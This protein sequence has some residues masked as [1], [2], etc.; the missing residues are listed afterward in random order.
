[1]YKQ[2][3]FWFPSSSRPV[4]ISTAT[5]LS[6]LRF[7]SSFSFFGLDLSFEE[8]NDANIPNALPRLEDCPSCSNQESTSTCQRASN[9]PFAISR[10]STQWATSSGPE[11]FNPR[12][13]QPT[14]SFF[15]ILRLALLLLLLLAML[16]LS[17]SK[18]SSRGGVVNRSSLYS[19][20]FSA[21]KI[22]VLLSNEASTESFE[23]HSLCD[24]GI[25][26]LPR[27]A[28][29]KGSREKSL[30]VTNILCSPVS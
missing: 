5:I 2:V 14:I 25:P 23:L 12:L 28:I 3:G 17:S 16:L 6:W 24:D 4:S 27:S 7:W 30:G 18:L 11:E 9:S 22:P 19:P 26:T 8:E 21:I 10:I 29:A 20:F 13:N 1:M 15:F